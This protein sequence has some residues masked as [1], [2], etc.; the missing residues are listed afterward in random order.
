LT[1]DRSRRL[2]TGRWEQAVNR[3]LERVNRLSHEDKLAI[4]LHH[5]QSVTAEDLSPLTTAT[6]RNIGPRRGKAV[7][8]IYLTHPPDAGE[9][10]AQL[11]TFDVVRL[12]PR[13]ARMS[14]STFC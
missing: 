3:A 1:A 9:P 13:E 5:F 14:R 6:V 8:Q 7:P 10:P 2:T 4:A 11:K 12:E